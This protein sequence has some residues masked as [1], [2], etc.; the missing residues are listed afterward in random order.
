MIWVIALFVL[1]FSTT[2]AVSLYSDKDVV[3]TTT[4]TMKIEAEPHVNAD[5]EP[6]IDLVSRG[7][8]SKITVSGV[9]VYDMIKLAK[10]GPCPEGRLELRITYD[11]IRVS[12]ETAKGVTTKNRLR[13]WRAALDVEMW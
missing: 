6:E 9:I 1:A 5:N 2:V 7:G 4:Q 13:D 12:A 10:E 11:T 3:T 8:E